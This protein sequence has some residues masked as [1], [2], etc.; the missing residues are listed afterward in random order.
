MVARGIYPFGSINVSGKV[1]W[2]EKDGLSSH[3]RSGARADLG[4]SRLFDREQ[5]FDAIH[6]F[7][8]SYS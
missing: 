6:S 2:D 5:H 7:I 4:V 8:H 3:S 1:G